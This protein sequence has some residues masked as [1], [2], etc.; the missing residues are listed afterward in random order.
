M[1][2][3]ASAIVI[4]MASLLVSTSAALAQPAAAP[5]H[6]IRPAPPAASGDAKAAA[7]SF[8]QSYAMASEFNFVVR[9]SAPLC[10]Q[11]RGLPPDQEAAVK[12]RMEAVGQALSLQVYHTRL[13]CGQ[14]RNVSVVFTNDPQ[15]TLDAIATHDP[16]ALGDVHSDTRNVRT[17]TR[18]IQAWYETSE[19]D[20]VCGPDRVHE[21]LINVTV[22]VDARRTASTKLSAIADYVAMVVLSEPR[23]PDRCQ[24]LPSVIDLFAG[25]CAGRAAPSGLTP[26]DLAYLKAVYSADGPIWQPPLTWARGDPSLDQVAGRMGMLLAGAAPLPAPGVRPVPD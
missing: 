8:V 12:A 16:R 13:S 10:L 15:R 2:N 11:V 1:P 23:F 21:H 18:P 24:V 9:L 19:C 4:L 25:P 20:D 5:A 22:L 14:V 3:R 6:A 17:V 7:S 26:T